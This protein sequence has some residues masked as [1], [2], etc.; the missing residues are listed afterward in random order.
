MYLSLGLGGLESGCQ[1]RDG[2]ACEVLGDYYS[3]QHDKS[4]RDPVKDK[5]YY[6]SACSAGQKKACNA[7]VSK[8]PPPPPAGPSAK[9]PPPPPPPR[10]PPPTPPN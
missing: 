3:G 4:V 6:D 7:P 10:K 9:G 8:G 5:K 1:R 2:E